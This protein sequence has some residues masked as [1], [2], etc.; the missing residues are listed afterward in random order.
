MRTFLLSSPSYF[1]QATRADVTC[2]GETNSAL[3]LLITSDASDDHRGVG[4]RWLNDPMACSSQ[5]EKKDAKGR[6]ARSRW[7]SS[8][9]FPSAPHRSPHFPLAIELRFEHLTPRR[10]LEAEHLA[11]QIET[12]V[13]QPFRPGQ[14][15]L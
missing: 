15:I 14:I 6:A 8:W 11:R 9:T 2:D 13:V 4:G 7:K 1:Q 10:R 5:N 3:T 12:G